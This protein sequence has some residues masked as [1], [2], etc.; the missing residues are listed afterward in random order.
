MQQKQHQQSIFITLNI[1]GIFTNLFHVNLLAVMD[2]SWKQLIFHF[3]LDKMWT[4]GLTLNY[5]T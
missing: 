2:K 3:P 4:V 5:T 1:I